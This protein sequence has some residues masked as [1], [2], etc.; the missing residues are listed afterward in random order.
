MPAVLIQKQNILSGGAATHSDLI[1]GVL[2]AAAGP[3][4]QKIGSP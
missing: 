3:G 2:N 1:M 4:K